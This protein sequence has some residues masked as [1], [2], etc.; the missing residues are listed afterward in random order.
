MLSFFPL[1]RR[2][3]GFAA[4]AFACLLLASSGQNGAEALPLRPIAGVDVTPDV[5]LARL[6]GG[7]RGRGLREKRAGARRHGRGSDDHANNHQNNHNPDQV[8]S[9][10]DSRP[11]NT[12]D[13]KPNGG[14]KNNDG[15]KNKTAGRT[16]MVGRTTMASLRHCLAAREG[17]LRPSTSSASQDAC[18]MA[19]AAAAP[20]K[21][22]RSWA[23]ASLPV[24][25]RHKGSRSRR[26]HSQE[27]GEGRWRRH[28]AIRK[29]HPTSR[30]RPQAGSQQ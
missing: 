29:P 30:R 14:G 24:R 21:A 25:A 26:W 16:T 4:V 23:V 28:K 20:G 17:I 18:A 3:L 22:G 12:N 1:L 27:P 10:G 2:L 11:T 6:R 19:N 7:K 9:P 15:G 13:G 8:G 5:S